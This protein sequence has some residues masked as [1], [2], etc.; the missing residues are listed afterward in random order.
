MMPLRG[1][2]L[3][4]ETQREDPEQARAEVASAVEKAIE[5][6]PQGQ[7]D[8]GPGRAAISQSS[9]RQKAG[10]ESSASPA[11]PLRAGLPGEDGI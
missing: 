7:A 5:V 4:A 1:S 11:S 8:R 3:H 10:R 2:I 6:T 9:S